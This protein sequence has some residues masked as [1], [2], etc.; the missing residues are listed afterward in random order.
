MAAYLILFFSAVVYGAAYAVFS[1]K[2]G[3]FIAAAT[4]IVMTI[5]PVL[6]LIASFC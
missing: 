1:I 4:A 2:K 3:P 6:L 5:A